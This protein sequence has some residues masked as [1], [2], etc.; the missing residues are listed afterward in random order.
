MGFKI[1][2][3]EMLKSLSGSPSKTTFLL[4]RVSLKM[5]LH[6]HKELALPFFGIKNDAGIVCRVSSFEGSGKAHTVRVLQDHI[7][8]HEFAAVCATPT[9]LLSTCMPRR[10][11][12]Y[13]PHTTEPS[14]SWGATAWLGGM[15]LCSSM[16]CGSPMRSA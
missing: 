12:C 9:G 2:A 8:P 7:L 11:S 6:F 5:G 14:A 1:Q 15:R 4:S 13:A 3:K 10:Q 16:M